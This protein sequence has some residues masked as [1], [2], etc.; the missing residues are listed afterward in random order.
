MAA[1]PLLTFFSSPPILAVLLSNFVNHI[2]QL[3]ACPGD[4][5]AEKATDSFFISR[6]LTQEVI[7]ATAMCY[8]SL[9]LP[10]TTT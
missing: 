1:L 9:L 3:Q 10:L 7:R 4:G 6:F 2:Q 8:A 5:R